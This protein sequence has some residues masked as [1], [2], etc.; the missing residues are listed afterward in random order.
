M[1]KILLCLVAIAPSFL[2]AQIG[3]KAGIN[4]A[5]VRGA[6]DINSSSRSGFHAGILFGGSPKK[7]LG[8]RT[9]LL[10]SQQGYNYKT[11]TN[12]GN[13]HLNYLSLHELLA[14]N[15]TK[16]FQLQIGTQFAYLL[17]AKA[18]SSANGMTSLYD[19]L[20]LGG[21]GK[22]INTF[23]RFDYGL[24]GGFEIHPVKGLLIGARICISFNNLY[25]MPDMSQSQQQQP[26]YS[27]SFSAKNNVI[28]AYVGWQFGKK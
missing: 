2:F 27:P 10:F 12:N 9:E 21:Y 14:I 24:A 28:Q 11:G 5:N 23:N 3:I 1:K 25:K 19:S 18:D 20:G 6:S 7:V 17:N 26:S 8:S 13:I 4:F 15:I 22:I 16:Y